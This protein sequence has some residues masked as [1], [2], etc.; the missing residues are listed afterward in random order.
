MIS[1]LLQLHVFFACAW[2]E[3][4]EHANLAFW[5]FAEKNTVLCF[6]FR[7]RTLSASIVLKEK[8]DTV[9]LF[10]WSKRI[11]WQNWDYVNSHKMNKTLKQESFFKKIWLWKVSQNDTVRKLV[12]DPPHWR[13]S[14][15][16]I[17][18]TDAKWNNNRTC[19][20]ASCY[21]YC[22]TQQHV[23]HFH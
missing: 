17:G 15:D 2:K 10:A 22:Q 19:A 9:F 5:Q 16:N 6:F 11:S 1:K 12:T 23:A 3:R 20:K 8:S 14:L 18:V 7:R 13:D 4:H 21:K